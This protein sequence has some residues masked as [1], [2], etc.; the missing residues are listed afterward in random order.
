MG[1]MRVALIW[2]YGM[3]TTIGL[4]LAL[5]YLKSN[6]D[7]TKYDMKIFD[8]ALKGKSSS[9]SLFIKEMAE[10]NPNVVCISCWSQAFPE[11]LAICKG[12]KSMNSEITT[13][14]G[15]P[16]P[17][18]YPEYVMENKEIDFLFR[19]EA[20]LTFQAF[21]EEFRKDSP[22]W[23]SVDGLAYRSDGN[24]VKNGM[25]RIKD[26]DVIKI[27]DYNA[28]NL[29]Q[30]IRKGYRYN[31][32]LFKRSAPIWATRGC[33][34][35]C[36]FCSAPLLNGRKI[37]RHS[38]DYLVEW[39]KFL[40]YEKGIRW[41]SIIDDNFTSDPQYVMKFCDAMLELNLKNLGFG[42]PNGIR[43]QMG[44]S[45]LWKKMKQTGW[46]SLIVAPESGSAVVLRRMRKDLKIENVPKVVDD[47]RKVGLKVQ[48]FLM[49]GFPGET[50]K[51]IEQTVELIKKCRFN[52]I[53]ISTFQP[54]PG[55]PI[56][57]DLVAKG[58]IANGILPKS[59]T[60]GEVTYITPGLR[61]FNF[62]MFVLKMYV[63][64]LLKNPLNIL[65]GAS[66]FPFH[67]IFKKLFLNFNNM[68]R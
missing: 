32:P 67:K 29:D 1:R 46:R 66:I 26:L 15:G 53:I 57:D 8:Y 51:D 24:V 6:T 42:N 27:P 21:L 13:V 33:P 34:Y 56:Y 17:A 60:D 11:S 45:E 23:S 20:E 30:Y 61:D 12:I 28:I 3:D 44:G 68:C 2:P 10:F 49:L 16:H 47:I 31:A 54:L 52:F 7:T 4:P 65:Y 64:M 62:P 35:R 48:A 39:I 41:I 37:R 9:S 50:L 40:Y 25:A 19:G 38:I 58:E 22:D 36:A 63:F 55:T 43:M 18:C 5:G 59:Y 14:I